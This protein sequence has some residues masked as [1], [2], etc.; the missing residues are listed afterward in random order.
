VQNT[1]AKV[2]INNPSLGLSSA[3]RLA[4]L[5][6]LPI[7]KRIDFK[8]ATLTY[9]IYRTGSPSYLNDLLHSYTPQRTL[10]SASSN[11]LSIPRKT[12]EA[13]R[14]GFSYA[15]PAIWNSIPLNI[16]QLPSLNSFKNQL[17]THYFKHP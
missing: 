10:R 9:R 5:H 1:L 4:H 2:T 8:I 7:K 17:K 12:T 16:R 3:A 15:A 14:R 13:G 6:W 11:L